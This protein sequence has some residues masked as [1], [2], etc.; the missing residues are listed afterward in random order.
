MGSVLRDEDEGVSRFWPW[1]NKQRDESPNKSLLRFV[2]CS[3]SE[4]KRKIVTAISFEMGAR[5]FYK[6]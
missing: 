4:S 2:F 6:R 1:T 3:H 5:Y